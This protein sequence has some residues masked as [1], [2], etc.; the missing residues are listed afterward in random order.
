MNKMHQRK[1]FIYRKTT[2][3]ICNYKNSEDNKQGNI[4][5]I[6]EKY[7]NEIENCNQDVENKEEKYE[8]EIED[9]KYTHTEDKTSD[10]LLDISI[11]KENIK[12]HNKKLDMIVK[13]GYEL[14]NLCTS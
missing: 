2:N 10:I 7:E 4:Q 12:R 3:P 1:S 9:N 6:E 11:Y 8:N 14:Y 5:V 13:L